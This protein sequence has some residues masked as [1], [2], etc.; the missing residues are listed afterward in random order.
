MKDQVIIKAESFVDRDGRLRLPKE[1]VVRSAVFSGKS[2][3]VSVEEK[4]PVRTGSQND[5]YF[6]AIV[7]PIT[8]FFVDC[9]EPFNEQIVHDILKTKFLGVYRPNPTTG[10][11]EL[12][13]VRSSSS[14]KVFEFSFYIEDCIRYAADDLGL[15]IEPPKTCRADFS[16]LEYPKE[17]E[18]RKRYLNRI[19]GYV[20]DISTKDDLLRYFKQNEDWSTDD[21]VKTIFRERLNAIEKKV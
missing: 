18:S 9:G 13:Y 3:I 2:V 15:V 5:Y 19:K 1:L 14:L 21:E 6:V 7:R 4:L 16:F 10:E 8:E 11:V 20:D 12:L 17:G